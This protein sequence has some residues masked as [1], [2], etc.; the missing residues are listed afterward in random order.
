MDKHFSASRNTELVSFLRASGLRRAEA[1]H[2]RGVDLRPCA[3]SPV[4]LGV[5]VRP[6]GAKGGRPRVAP[7]YCSPQ[8]AQQIVDRCAAI[9]NHRLFDHIHTKLDV[10]SIRA[11]YA[12]NVYTHNARENLLPGER[13]HCRGDM[14]GIVLDRQAMRITSNALGHNRIQVATHYLYGLQSQ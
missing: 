9:G 11:D 3:E 8:T 7:L 4:G 6:S 12:L 2:A 5:Y 14:K 10:H 1:T 13:Y